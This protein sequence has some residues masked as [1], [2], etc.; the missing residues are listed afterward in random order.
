MPEQTP[1]N[2]SPIRRPRRKLPPL[3]DVALPFIAF[4][5]G[6]LLFFA[7]PNIVQAHDIW[8]YLKAGVLALSAT[9]V[10]FG[11]NKL[12]IER[13]A[14]LAT[15]GYLGAGLTS[16]LSIVAVGFGLFSATYAG[17]TFPD[18]AELQLQ[19]HG[20]ALS[21]FVGERSAA[22]AEASRV[23]PAINAVVA[24]LA[25][26]RDCELAESCISGRGNG[27]RGPVARVIEGYAGRAASIGEQITAG[28]AARQGAVDALNAGLAEYQ[29]IF[30]D[31]AR[32]IW[33]RRAA[34]QPVDGKLRQ[35]AS[36]LDQAV[37]VSLLAAY[38]AE[39]QTG[40][41]IPARPEAEAR[42]NAILKNHGQTLAAV[43]G[44]IAAEDTTPLS[45]PGRTG[46]SDTLQ[47]LMHFLPIAAIAAVVELIFPL[48]LWG[49][50]FWALSWEKDRVGLL[51]AAHAAGEGEVRPATVTAIS[52]P[53]A[54]PTPQP[55]KA[56]PDTRR[57]YRR[58]GRA[59][60]DA[61]DS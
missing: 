56:L 3:L 6:L 47:Y 38:A 59:E 23:T 5:S 31:E 40:V 48:V 54:T 51:A 18:V 58:N 57:P 49:Y 61:L 41:S 50:T 11:V 16:I 19:Q 26:K 4:C 15:T 46:V 45:F 60:R 2:N 44:S 21:E 36:A 32:S 43:I 24:D 35:G 22:A 37:P 55:A 7:L 52:T 17:L 34:L 27:G 30:G 1:S 8:S 10:S 39:L 28:E 42:L 29:A 25:Q 12:A 53:P 14:P 9:T 13:G 20:T 33:E